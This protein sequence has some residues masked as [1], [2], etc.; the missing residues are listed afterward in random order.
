MPVQEHGSVTDLLI[1]ARDGNRAALDRLVPVIY[2]ELRAIAH[3][4]LRSERSGHTLQTTGL[5]HEAYLKLV[6]QTRIHWR[7]RAHFFAAAAGAMRRIL[8]DHARKYLAAK[9]GG[10]D[11][12]VTLEPEEIAAD[13]K[14]D[15]LVAV[16]I[17]LQRLAAIDDRMS[18]IVEHRFF[19]GLT[20]DETA[21]AL[22]ISQRTVRREWAKAKGWL[23]QELNEDVLP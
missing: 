10:G 23:F 14:A 21:E 18:R 9:R 5:V 6:G 22:G 20:E 8:V 2:E 7:D 15:T 3:R 16:D 11:R 13:E 19:A 12:C 17:A 1:H 4:Q